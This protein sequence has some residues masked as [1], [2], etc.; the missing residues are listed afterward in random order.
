MPTRKTS[1]LEVL[2]QHILFVLPVMDQMMQWHMDKPFRKLKLRR[3][4]S[5]KKALQKICNELTSKAGPRTLIGFGD[6]SNRDTAGIIKKSPAGPVKKLEAELKKRCRVVPVDEFR[7]SK[8]HHNCGCP[9]HNRWCHK[10]KD[11]KSR[12]TK[13]HKVL[14]CANSSC[15]G[16]SMDRDENASRNILRLLLLE[17]QGKPR[18]PHFCRGVE[19]TEGMAAPFGEA[20][21]WL[22]N[23]ALAT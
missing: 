17:V 3:Y 22:V 9:M 2:K 13:I 16:I 18:P 15:N 4:I 21:V 19:L 5:S 7:T 23:V 1:H 11:G 10:H 20:G 6:W 8:L 12:L 14:Y